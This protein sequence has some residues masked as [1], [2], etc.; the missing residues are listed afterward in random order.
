MRYSAMTEYSNYYSV[1]VLLCVPVKLVA[2]IQGFNCARGQR[3][4]FN[5]IPS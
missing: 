2:F 1:I 3:I 4:G 5:H